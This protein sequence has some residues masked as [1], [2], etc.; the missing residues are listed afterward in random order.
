MF[1]SQGGYTLLETIVAIAIVGILTTIVVVAFQTTREQQNLTLAQQHLQFMLRD[2][3]K[4]ALQEEREGDCLDRPEEDRLCSDIGVYLNGNNVVLFADV[5][6]QFGTYTND[7]EDYVL[8]EETLPNNVA[9]EGTTARSFLFRA[10]PPTIT[11]TANG[12]EVTPR[13][14]FQLRSGRSTRTLYLYSYGHLDTK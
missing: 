8:L 6:P 14:E 4:K 5:A 2:A 7:T 11:L 1:S 9:L 10:V 3:Q 12:A 13:V